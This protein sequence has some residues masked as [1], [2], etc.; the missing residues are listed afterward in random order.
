MYQ[1][2]T[3]IIADTVSKPASHLADTPPTVAAAMKATDSKATRAPGMATYFAVWTH[4]RKLSALTSH[5]MGR[6]ARAR[7]AHP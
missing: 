1:L 6:A 4:P 3:H 7:A 5:S 2:R